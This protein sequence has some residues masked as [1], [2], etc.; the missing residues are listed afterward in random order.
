MIYV[1]ETSVTWITN[2]ETKIE[3]KIDKYKRIIKSL[4]I[5]YPNYSVEQITF[6][7]DCYSKSLIESEES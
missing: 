3:E 6:I 5:M 4:K 2:R 1:L 7:I